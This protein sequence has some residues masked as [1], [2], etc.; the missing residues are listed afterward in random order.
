VII[1]QSFGIIHKDFTTLNFSFQH[2]G[3]YIG[4]YLWNWL[5]PPRTFYVRKNPKN[6]PQVELFGLWRDVM[7]SLQSMNTEEIHEKIRC[8][9]RNH[10]WR[11][12]DLLRAVIKY[13]NSVKGTEL[14]VL[15]NCD[16]SYWLDLTPKWYPKELDV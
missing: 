3:E 14:E 5:I 15:E 7:R 11:E 1:S 13:V 12:R 6:L 16:G 4:E 10:G 8:R 9:L 2:P